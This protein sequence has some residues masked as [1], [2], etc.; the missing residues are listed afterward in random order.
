MKKI[1]KNNPKAEKIEVDNLQRKRWNQ[2]VD[3][4]LVSGVPE[5]QIIDVKKEKIGRKASRSI[6]QMGRQPDLYAHI[7]MM[8]IKVLEFLIM[9]K[10]NKVIQSVGRIKEGE[11]KQRVILPVRQSEGLV[12]G[13]EEPEQRIPDRPKRTILAAKY[14][15][16]EKIYEQLQ[17]QNNVIYHKEQK[18]DNLK[19]ELADCK[20]IFKGKKRKELKGE[21]QQI[22]NQL[23]SRKQK[24][25][26]TVTVYGYQNVKEF[27]LEYQKAKTEYANYMQAS[28]NWEQRYGREKESKSVCARLNQHKEQVKQRELNRP[29]VKKRG[30]GAR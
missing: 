5:Q 14:P 30:R 16:L 23:E 27:L 22:Q 9:Q 25:T 10:I 21:I 8:A 29:Y 7:I 20:G 17:Q 26:S 13:V 4:A 1:G 6:R 18:L 2:T 12:V 24:L 15:G 3:R 28:A 11:K 19:I